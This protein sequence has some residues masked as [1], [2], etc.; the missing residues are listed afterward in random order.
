MHTR[1][2]ARAHTR[3][4]AH[5]QRDNRSSMHRAEITNVIVSQKQFEEHAR[6][7]AHTHAREYA[8]TQALETPPTSTN[9]HAH[10][11]VLDQAWTDLKAK[12]ILFARETPS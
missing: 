10:S 4:L 7:H 9:P 5:A 2:R 1:T 12:D 3:A 6:T 8:R 11:Y